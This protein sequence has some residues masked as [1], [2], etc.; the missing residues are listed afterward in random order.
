MKDVDD[1]P[2]DVVYKADIVLTTFEMVQADRS[3]LS[4]VPWSC[5]VVD[6]AHRLKNSGGRAARDLRSLDFS[7]RVVLLTGTPLQNDTAELWSL[8]NFVDGRR[9]TE[10]DEFESRFG[11]VKRAGQVEA[12]HKVLAPYLLRR[13][14][15][16]VEHKLPPRVETL[17]ECELMPLQ[18]KCYRARSS[19]ET[20]SFFDTV[21]A[22]TARWPTSTTS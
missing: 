10:K 9:F 20:S 7:G 15:Q 19:S 2:V 8:L 22:T 21:V 1:N 11:A 5:L 3:V 4:K 12:L 18:K 13:L 16:D 17:I 14:K 6:E